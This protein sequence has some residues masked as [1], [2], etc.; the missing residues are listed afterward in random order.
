MKPSHKK[1]PFKRD[2]KSQHTR[3][4]GSKN[5]KHAPRASYNSPLHPKD[6]GDLASL[7]ENHLGFKPRPFQINA[8]TSQMLG[9]DTIVHAGTGMGKTVIAI[10]PHFHPLSRGRL[11]IMVSPLIAL[12]NEQLESF[13]QKG[14]KAIALN[15]QY[16]GCSHANLQ[17]LKN[18]DYQVLLISPELL[19]SKRF[20]DTMMRDRE[21]TSRILSVVVDEAHVV[22]SWGAGFRK[23]Y[24]ELG[25]I[26]AF[27]PKHVPLVAMSATLPA[28]V[29][30]DVAQKLEFPQDGYLFVNIGNDRPNVSI[31]VRAIHNTMKT[32]SDL[33]FIIPKTMRHPN[34]IPSTLVYGDNVQEG[35][36]IADNIDDKLPE[37][38][39][40][41]GL[42]RPFNA[43]FSQAY[44]EKVLRLFKLGI[45][46][47][48]VCT[49]AAGMGCDLPK[50]E[51][52]VQW[53]MPDSISTF[54]QRAGRA[55]RSPGTSGMAV[56]LV[57]KS[58]YNVD[59]QTLNTQTTTTQ[60]IR[61]KS[62]NP[63]NANKPAQSTDKR[64][65]KEVQM[66]AAACGAHRGKHS[67][68]SDEL[69]STRLEPHIDVEH[70]NEG[71]Y[72]LIQTTLCRRRVLLTVYDN[73]TADP[74]DRKVCCDLC[75]PQLL[76]R[77]RPG[78]PPAKERRKV[79][80]K[81]AEIALHVWSKLDE[82]R[83]LVHARDWPRSMLGPSAILSDDDLEML[84]MAENITT[85]EDLKDILHQWTWRTKYVDELWS[86]WGEATSNRDHGPEVPAEPTSSSPSASNAR[87]SPLVDVPPAPIPRESTPVVSQP[88]ST[89]NVPRQPSV[90]DMTGST[91]TPVMLA[92][93][94]TTRKRTRRAEDLETVGD[95]GEDDVHS[96]GGGPSQRRRTDGGNTSAFTS[97]L[98]AASSHATPFNFNHF[99]GRHDLAFRPYPTPPDPQ[100]QALQRYNFNLAP[101]YYSHAVLPST[102]ARQQ[103]LYHPSP[104][105]N[106]QHGARYPPPPIYEDPRIV[107]AP[108][109]FASQSTPVPQAQYQRT[110]ASGSLPTP[111]T[112]YHLP[113]R[114]YEASIDERQGART[115]AYQP[116]FQQ[117]PST[118]FPHH[119]TQRTPLPPLHVLH[120]GSG[121]QMYHPP[122]PG[123]TP[124]HRRHN[125]SFN[126]RPSSPQ[127]PNHPLP[128]PPI[129]P[130]S[131]IP[132]T[133]HAQYEFILDARSYNNDFT[134]VQ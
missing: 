118:A 56:L 86:V 3:S 131:H 120:T 113:A 16:G 69:P 41:R 102:P 7:L 39:R 23:K 49:D 123:D 78:K 52:V 66:Y 28:R 43:G 27:L 91:S 54:V 122:T 48:L 119:T 63:T 87:V 77:V 61:V 4:R 132:P 14:I 53:K 13:N 60:S 9:K 34:D 105:T 65:K 116:P 1:T 115:S 20:L 83:M 130:H 35:P 79:V 21:F 62:V 25:M 68:C 8:V 81:R 74:V 12:Q 117:T 64:T 73:H 17:K 71:L 31:V 57:E 10:G 103:S 107:Q 29:R 22:S 18:G 99:A 97:S 111:G 98:T 11:T 128:P 72:A 32:Y 70:S 40:R 50:V 121:V 92:P 124:H 89:H 133:N 42:V 2:A 95:G 19:L 6:L 67:G 114:H 37:E 88:T 94:T 45:V 46:R 96:N 59:L 58:A 100:Y 55:A 5:E 93:T 82:W 110:Y 104:H 80:K 126:G 125:L 38:W 108:V 101:Q 24:G 15:S 30:Y 84:A 47:V 85:L 51:L 90:R 75:N 36:V 44:R 112:P 129:T 26:R 106:L 76:D 127:W 134:N 33:D 109:S